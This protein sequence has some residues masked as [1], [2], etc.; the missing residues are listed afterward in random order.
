MIKEFRD[1]Y[2]LFKFWSE[3]AF[4]SNRDFTKIRF[5]FRA[6]K[7]FNKDKKMIN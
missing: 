4:K 6:S 7:I 1:L 5:T 2:Y 3:N